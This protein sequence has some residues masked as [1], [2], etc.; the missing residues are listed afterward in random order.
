MDA[1][2]LTGRI[3]R[4]TAAWGPSVLRA[5]AAMLWLANVNWKVPPAFGRAG[6]RC[7]ALCR[8]VEAGA[9]NPVVP[10]SAWF[11]EHVASP[12]LALF[13]WITLLTESVLVVLLVSGRFVR[14]AAVV[15]MAMSFG[16]GL[17]VA[18]AEHEWYWSYLLMIALHLAIL[19]T[20][21]T[22]R[23]QSARAT[24]V[25]VAVYGVVVAIAHA[26]AGVSGAGDWLLFDQANDFPGDWG[27][28]TFPGSIALGV[29]FVALA[30]IVWAVA[31]RPC[32]HRGRILGWVLIGVAACLLFSYRSDGLVI[33]LGSRAGSAA[34]L[35]ALGLSLAVPPPGERE[36]AA[37]PTTPGAERSP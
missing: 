6:E 21:P 3:D 5:T 12:N 15:G 35:A 20:A 7:V 10:G 32:P 37:E 24:A 28:S 23:V 29:A 30:A 14:I 34:M 33:G 13:G 11:F 26:G 17:A 27:R 18:N 2:T 36:P 9:E 25:V 4:S 8:F 16:I 19:V 31:P 22:A 1:R